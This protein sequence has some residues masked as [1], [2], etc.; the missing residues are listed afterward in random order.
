[1]FGASSASFGRFGDLGIVA[2]GAYMLSVGRV[3]EDG[4]AGT[5]HRRTNTVGSCRSCGCALI[6]YEYHC[7][8]NSRTEV[9]IEHNA[10]SYT[11]YLL[12]VGSSRFYRY[13][14]ERVGTYARPGSRNE[15]RNVTRLA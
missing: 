13:L 12:T 14:S 8:L 11:V 6:S 15:Y 2:K 3:S 1:M 9:G 7:A 4:R 5:R 10:C